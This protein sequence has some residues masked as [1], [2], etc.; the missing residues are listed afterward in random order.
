MCSPNVPKLK[1]FANSLIFLHYN[2][3][4]IFFYCEKLTNSKTKIPNVKKF[5]KNSR[6]LKKLTNS[7]HIKKKMCSTNLPKFKL[8]VNLLIFLHY[9]KKSIFFYREK[10]TNSKTKIPIVK[11]FSKNSLG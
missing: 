5:S 7:F 6:G 3:K 1:L 8:F 2:K 4:P 9:N 10:L 11:K